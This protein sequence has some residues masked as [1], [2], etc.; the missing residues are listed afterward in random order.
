MQAIEAG[1][2][3]IGD[4]RVKPARMLRVADVV[5]VRKSSIVWVVDVLRLSDRRGGAADAA[6]L[7]VERPDSVRAREDRLQEL[8]AARDAVGQP[9]GRPTK[10]QRRKLAD[11]LNEP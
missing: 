11:F 5:S 8:R 2:A 3:R 6:L 9:A 10:R 7:Y 4:E 1:Q